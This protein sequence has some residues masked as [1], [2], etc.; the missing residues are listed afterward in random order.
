MP[1]QRM[2]FGLGI[3]EVGQHLVKFQGKKLQGIASAHRFQGNFRFCP[4]YR[5]IPMGGFNLS[6]RRRSTRAGLSKSLVT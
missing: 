4:S 6:A 5:S 3:A 2:V 1:Y